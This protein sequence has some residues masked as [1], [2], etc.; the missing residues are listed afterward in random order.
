[1]R[2]QFDMPRQII[3]V[4]RGFVC[5]YGIFPGEPIRRRWRTRMGN[6]AQTGQIELPERETMEFDVVIVGA[7]AGLSAAI[8]LK[9]LAA[10]KGQGYL[11]GGARKGLRSGG[12][13]PFRR[14]YRSYRPQLGRS[15]LAGGRRAR[16]AAGYGGPLPLSRASRRHPY[17]SFYLSA[18]DVE[19][20]QLYCKPWRRG[21]M[22]CRAG[23][24]AGR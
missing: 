13:H 22:A 20:R 3:K 24:G 7:G 1:M 11:G 17:T 16:N 4:A 5:M 10:G 18:P 23:R 8:R 6:D 14:R 2:C 21:A 15:Q 19:P 12:A 9:Q